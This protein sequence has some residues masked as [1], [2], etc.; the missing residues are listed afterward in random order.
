MEITSHLSFDASCD[1]VAQMLTDPQFYQF[2]GDHL[3]ATSVAATPVDDGL[4]AS[5][6]VPAPEGTGKWIGAHLNLTETVIW[7]PASGDGSRNGR[8]ALTLSGFPATM[9]GPIKLE[10]TN[11]GCSMDYNAEFTVRIPLIGKKV[12]NMAGDSMTRL[13]HASET[14]GNSWL[15]QKMIN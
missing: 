6:I 11:Q 4:T 5:M 15:A 9:D 8:M 1:A 10:P 2:V 3:N 13:V 12:E 14:L 7:G